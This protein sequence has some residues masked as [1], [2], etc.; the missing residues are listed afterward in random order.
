MRRGAAPAPGPAGPLWE[1]LRW[2]SA[3][4]AFA[5]AALASWH[6]LQAVSMEPPDPASSLLVALRALAF[7]LWIAPPFVA[8]RLGG[9]PAAA[10]YRPISLSAGLGYL[11]ADAALT[12]VRVAG[13]LGTPF[14]PG[15]PG[16]LLFL[17][18]TRYG[19]LWLL[20]LAL[21]GV[22][23]LLEWRRAAPGWI[24]TGLLL[25]L[26]VLVALGAHA[27]S[28]PR[29]WLAVPA[30]VLHQWAVGV[31]L[32]GVLLLS[33]VERPRRLRQGRELTREE[34]GRFSGLAARALALVVLSG[35]V[36][37]TDRFL[38]LPDPLRSDYGHALLVKLGFWAL[39]LLAAGSH[40]FWTARRLES[41][42]AARQRPRPGRLFARALRF[43]AAALLLVLLATGVL[44]GSSPPDPEEPLPGYALAWT[45]EQPALP[46]WAALVGVGLAAVVA[47][48]VRAR[49]P[50]AAAFALP[51]L[52]LAG[53]AL[54][55]ANPGWVLGRPAPSR[56]QASETAGPYRLELR[57]S[58][59]VIGR[60]QLALTVLSRGRPV[61]GLAV[62]AEVESLDMEMGTATV[63]LAPGG[64]GR[65]TGST[66][67]F[68]M[69]GGWQVVLT[70][71][72]SARPGAAAA[73]RPAA[74]GPS[75]QARFQLSVAP[76]GASPDCSWAIDPAL[77]PRRTD[78]GAPVYAI[79]PSPRSAATLLVGTGD[80]AVWSRDGGR[81]WHRVALARGRAVEAAAIA[82][83]GRTWYLGAGDRFWLST[84]G[85]V[86]WRAGR[87][88]GRSVAAILPSPWHPGG[89]WAATEAGIAYSPD[90]GRSWRLLAGSPQ[91]RGVI[92]LA[93]DPDRTG[94]LFAGG[95][96]GLLRSDDGGRS[97]RL[98]ER[99]ARLAYRILVLPRSVV[100]AAAMDSGA[101]VSHDGGGS[102]EEADQGIFVKGLMGLAAWEGGRQLVAGSMGGGLARSRDG[103]STWQTV[104]CP[105]ATVFYL[106]GGESRGRPLI[107]VGDSRG[108]LRLEPQP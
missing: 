80:G 34:L 78:L 37:A 74:E 26:S 21:A 76:P 19:R 107:W 69:A 83:D 90:R 54:L 33:L 8:S 55:V 35:L 17:E 20:R 92:A 1:G 28:S 36:S 70:L 40:R 68:S 97:W 18:A 5:L 24:Q 30:D 43:E 65:Y 71:R 87:A 66:D 72:S 58:P 99:R 57:V 79:A 104:A 105:T 49:R 10:P 13:V 38:P 84:D 89:L 4:G 46:L 42:D 86:H 103:G 75:F 77:R 82:P 101:W 67:A 6:L 50:H 7:A 94:R 61:D 73:G 9:S 53:G 60:N 11:L 32:G 62:Q 41:A 98:V 95:A 106:T 25:A 29:P 52:L 27:G 39:A 47:V 88:P 102:W 2:A 23:W 64:S 91:L 12:W 3:T 100:W 63:R 51:G 81:S 93:A 15:Q 96:E 85:G 59:A 56:Y 31:W 45:L 14:P 48:P 108:L 44:T 16:A 22:A